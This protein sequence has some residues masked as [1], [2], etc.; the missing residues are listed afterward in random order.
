M[1]TCRLTIQ[2]AGSGKSWVWGY[3]GLHET[4]LKMIEWVWVSA[5]LH[6]TVS[7]MIVCE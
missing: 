3:P 6:E 4:F 7:K 5:G 1:C 2:E